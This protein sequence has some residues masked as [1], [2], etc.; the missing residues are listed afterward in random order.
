MERSLLTTVA[1]VSPHMLLYT[2]GDR[3]I[4][5]T[6]IWGGSKPDEMM[7]END[8]NLPVKTRPN[9]QP[10]PSYELSS[11]QGDRIMWPLRT[12][13]LAEDTTIHEVADV[14]TACK[15]ITSPSRL[16]C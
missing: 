16:H 6:L 2:S 10:R 13:R 4:F 1:R 5:T 12:V 11:R 7:S 8:F 9:L 3:T 15:K 14:T